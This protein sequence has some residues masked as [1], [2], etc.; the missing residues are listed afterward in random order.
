MS[1]D[2]QEMREAVARLSPDQQRLVARCLTAIVRG[3]YID[4]D[5]EFDA[6]MGVTRG[7]AAEA[8]EAWPEAAAHGRSH[9]TVNNAMNNLLGYPHGQWR[10]LSR[11]LEA[12]EADVAHALMAWRGEDRREGG[13]KGYFDALM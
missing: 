13:G 7:E 10:Q 4:D 11:E 3:P 8:L 2:A 12:T 9:Y 5:D 6:V 1:E